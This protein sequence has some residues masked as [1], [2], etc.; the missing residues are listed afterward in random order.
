MVSPTVC[1]GF[2]WVLLSPLQSKT[3]HVDVDTHMCECV[4]PA[5]SCNIVFMDV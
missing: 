4:W 3:M 5:M 2:L 1:A